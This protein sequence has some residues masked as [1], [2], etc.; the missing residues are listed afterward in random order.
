M[1]ALHD[2]HFALVADA[3]SRCDVVVVSIFVNPLQF[4][5][6]D[7]FDGYPRPINDDL[8]ACSTHRVDAVYAPTAHAMYP[9]GFVGYLALDFG[10]DVYLACKEI[11]RASCRERV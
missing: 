5:R 6:R 7:D 9:E 3:R 2:G 10:S 8:A 1:G 11:G 4:D